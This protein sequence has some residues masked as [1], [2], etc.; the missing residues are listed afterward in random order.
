MITK[1]PQ[2]ACPAIFM[3]YPVSM[4]GARMNITMGV[5]MMLRVRLDVIMSVWITTSDA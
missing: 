4:M 5:M 3:T 2:L 1:V